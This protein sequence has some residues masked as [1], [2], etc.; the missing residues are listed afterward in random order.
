M[1]APRRSRRA[2]ARTLACAATLGAAM[3]LPTGA[4]AQGRVDSPVVAAEILPGWTSASGTRI[5]ALHLT[6]TP[7]WHTYWRIPGEAGIAPRFDWG[8][9]QNVA[10]VVPICLTCSIAASDACMT[11]MSLKADRLRC[12]FHAVR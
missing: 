9:S 7:G 11:R 1:K 5:A 3:L 8:R 2:A 12:R 10:S 6:L 4:S